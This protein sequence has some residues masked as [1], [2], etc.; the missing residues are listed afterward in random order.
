MA[1]KYRLELIFIDNCSQ[2]ATV[3]RITELCAHDPRVKLIVNARNFGHVRS[4]FHAMLQA[5]GVAVIGMASDLEDPPEL[6]P[7]FIEAWEQGASVVAGV[8]EQPINF[9][10]L[11]LARKLYY[12]II[13]TV[14][15]AQPIPA[16]TGFGLYD[17]RIVELLRQTAGPYP[18]VRGLVS[19]FGLPIKT[20]TFKKPKRSSGA[21][22]QTFLT[23]FDFSI[24]GLTSMSRAPIRIATLLGL[25]LSIVGFSIAILYLIAK[26]VFWSQFP[27]GQA[28]LLIG[29]FLFGSVQIFITG[30]VGEYIASLHQRAQNFPHVVER[31]RLNFGNTEAIDTTVNINEKITR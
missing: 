14:A 30:L 13:S 31:W 8:Y 16:F 25:I 15:E 11:G 6:I 2:D 24:L 21:S 23:L 1:H 12:R 4:P 27:L 29:I 10:L 22:T 9:G 17:R 26:L 18:Y 5:G 28:P 7:Q 3:E 20:I 19:E